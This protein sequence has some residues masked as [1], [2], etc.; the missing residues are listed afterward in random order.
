MDASRSTEENTPHSATRVPPQP[1]GGGFSFSLRGAAVGEH[2]NTTIISPSLAFGASFQG[3]QANIKPPKEPSPYRC[4]STPPR[5][6][7]QNTRICR[8]LVHRPCA[9]APQSNSQR[10]RNLDNGGARL[11]RPLEADPGHRTRPRSLLAF[12]NIPSFAGHL[13]LDDSIGRP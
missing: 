5:G 4:C 2:D 11:H 7:P 9:A 3:C 12:W 6:R 13:I 8:R 1:P 10:S